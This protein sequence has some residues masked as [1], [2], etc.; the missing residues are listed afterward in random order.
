VTPELLLG[1]AALGAIALLPVI[2]RRWRGG[3]LADSSG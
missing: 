2:L 1:L 3:R